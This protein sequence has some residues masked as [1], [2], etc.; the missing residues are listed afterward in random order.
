MRE[1]GEVITVTLNGNEVRV[2]IRKIDVKEFKVKQ[3]NIIRGS[4]THFFRVH[5]LRRVELVHI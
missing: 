2:L 1:E 4:L 5:F 3:R